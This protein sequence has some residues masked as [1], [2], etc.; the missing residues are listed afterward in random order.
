MQRG[1]LGMLPMPLRSLDSRHRPAGPRPSSRSR[2]LLAQ[3]RRQGVPG[4]WD[5]LEQVHEE[6]LALMELLVAAGCPP[7]P[8]TGRPPAAWELGRLNR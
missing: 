8:D 2:R 6:D 4:W 5:A 7:P 3:M 1:L